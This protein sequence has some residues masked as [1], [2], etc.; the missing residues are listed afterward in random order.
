[1][2]LIDWVGSLAGSPADIPADIG[3]LAI[4]A[5]AAIAPEAVLDSG[6]VVPSH[7]PDR[8]ANCIS[9]ISKH[10]STSSG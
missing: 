4:V 1:M 7:Y 9:R 8:L 3:D 5:V 6:I 2:L 10:G